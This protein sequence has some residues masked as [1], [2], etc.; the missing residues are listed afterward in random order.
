MFSLTDAEN[1]PLPSVGVNVIS[2]HVRMALFDKSAP[3]SIIS[4]VYTVPA[5]W[6][7]EAP[8]AWRFSARASLFYPKDDEN[9][10]LVRTN[11][12][13]FNLC[14][15]F[16][17]CVVVGKAVGG[18]AGAPAP[19]SKADVAE[20]SCGWG[21]LPLYS[22][23]GKPVE[24]KSYP[25]RLQG[26][27]PEEKDVTLEDGHIGGPTVR[28]KG[29]AETAD[30]RVWVTLP[31]ADGKLQGLFHPNRAPRLNLRVSRLGKAKMN[32]V[33][34]LPDT[35]VTA[36]A[37]VPVLAV[38]RRI[39][40]E[41]LLLQHDQPSVGPMFNPVLQIVPRMANDAEIMRCLTSRWDAE[42][43][44]ATRTELVGLLPL[45]RSLSTTD[46]R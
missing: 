2:R 32:E 4:N 42:R 33:N 30:R 1:V 34:E 12:G 22:I 38:Y 28:S 19:G 5:I 46:R 26:G 44:R 10:C 36:L 35:I 25:I 31:V 39:Q 41:A 20:L 24:N 45:A 11:I 9:T 37:N 40:A 16:E 7:S 17:L 6:Q 8:K 3:N 43:K 21:V 29:T 14:V 18:E 23:E 27:T 13:D 15:L